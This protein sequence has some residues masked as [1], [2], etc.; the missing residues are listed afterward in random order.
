VGQYPQIST[1][2]EPLILKI[3]HLGTS[4][5]T[6]PILLERVLISLFSSCP[7]ASTNRQPKQI[8]MYFSILMYTVIWQ[9]KFAWRPS[10]KR[11]ILYQRQWVSYCDCSSI[12]F[13]SFI[14]NFQGNLIYP[15]PPLFQTQKMI[16]QTFITFDLNILDQISQLFDTP[17]LNNFMPTKRLDNGEAKALM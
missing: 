13:L 17:F 14:S 2:F 5:C 10:G 6:K 4:P 8:F 16:F 9:S 1:N 3:P 15:P 11:L 7:C 12:T